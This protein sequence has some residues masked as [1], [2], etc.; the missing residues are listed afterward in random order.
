MYVWVCI[1][2]TIVKNKILIQYVFQMEEFRM[3]MGSLLPRIPKNDPPQ[4]RTEFEGLTDLLNY[5]AQ[6]HESDE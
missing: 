3:K 4:G 1:S 2:Q 6:S 5:V